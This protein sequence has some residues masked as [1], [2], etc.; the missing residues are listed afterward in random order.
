MADVNVSRQVAAH[1]ASLKAAGVDF[2][3]VLPQI[4]PPQVTPPRIE[5]APAVETA[6]MPDN[7]HV[8]CGVIRCNLLELARKTLEHE[9]QRFPL[10]R[11]ISGGVHEVEGEQFAFAAHLDFGAGQ[12]L[13]LS[14][15]GFA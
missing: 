5:I 12:T 14:Q 7:H 15:S 8:S 10:W 3:A 6:A 2:V 9:L 1:L 11:T 4:A 13:P